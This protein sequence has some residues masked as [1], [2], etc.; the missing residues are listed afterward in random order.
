[1]E[2]NWKFANPILYLLEG[3]KKDLYVQTYWIFV[4]VF[5]VIVF[6]LIAIGGF[7]YDKMKD[8]IITESVKLFIKAIALLLFLFMTILVIPFLTL[9]IQGFHCEED[10]LINYTIDGISCSGSEHTLLVPFSITT[11]ILLLLVLMLEQNLLQ[12]SRLGS[13]FAW[14]GFD[15][16][17]PFIRL[18]VKVLL[19]ASFVLDKTSERKAELML[20][21]CVFSLYV[22][23]RRFQASIHFDRWVN[24]AIFSLQL[25]TSQ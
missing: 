17:T 12:Q 18:I 8:G 25:C 3:N 5:Y 1:M 4:G 20:F 19:I 22:L 15:R 6:V 16:H 21:A 23:I 2:N 11:I 13:D 10:P 9:L 24:F 7:L 14:A